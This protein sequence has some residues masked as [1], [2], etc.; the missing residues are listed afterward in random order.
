MFLEWNMQIF[1]SF[2]FV[3]YSQNIFEISV[4]FAFCWRLI[5]FEYEFL[6]FYLGCPKL[7]L[8][9][10]DK[11]VCF[12]FTFWIPYCDLN[13]LRL[14]TGSCRRVAKQEQNQIPQ[15]M[16]V[17]P[18]TKAAALYHLFRRLMQTT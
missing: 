17:C 9:G 3:Q 16:T 2:C 13:I 1:Y 10:H 8:L 6:G 4:I 11:L 18:S 14:V 7:L 12:L 15:Q 5:V